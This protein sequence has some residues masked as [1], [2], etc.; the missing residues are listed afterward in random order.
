MSRIEG[1][2]RLNGKPV[3]RKDQDAGPV[4]SIITV[5]YNSKAFLKA[6]IQ[7]VICQTYPNIEYII[8]DGGSSDGTLDVIRAYED[9]I[10]YWISEKDDGIYDA[11]NKGLNCATGDYIWYI[12]AGDRINEPDT[13]KSIIKS[14]RTIDTYYGDTMLIDENGNFLGMR[15]LRPP[16]NLNWKS[17]GMGLVV[18]HQAI[19]IKREL[20]GNYNLNYKIAADFDW[21]M[22]ALKKSSKNRNTGT[23][24]IKYLQDGFSRHHVALSLRERF[25][26]MIKHYGLIL[27]LWFHFR[28][29]L[30]LAVFF[31]KKKASSDLK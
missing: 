7:S 2:I 23:I 18:C 4:I 12:N 16:E 13:L 1:G 27:T 5:V 17:L 6:T 31:I 14:D 15:R 24:I 28:I 10:N 22:N 20:A 11:M 3:A 29:T 25:R 19:I 30:R 8:I 21:V 9:K 26:I